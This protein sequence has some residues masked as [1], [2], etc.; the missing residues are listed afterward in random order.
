M[1][2]LSNW[3]DV[4]LIICLQEYVYTDTIFHSND[5]HVLLQVL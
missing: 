3:M 1:T 5:N 2:I 4:D